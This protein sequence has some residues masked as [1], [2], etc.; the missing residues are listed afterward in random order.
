MNAKFVKG[1]VV[2]YDNNYCTIADVYTVKNK[3]MYVLCTF[4][5]YNTY[6]VHENELERI[7][8]K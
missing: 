8:K 6:T 3:N 4:L 2:I 5:S 7:I 1:E